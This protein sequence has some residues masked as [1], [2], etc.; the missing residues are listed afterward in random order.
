MGAV[1]SIAI[2][3]TQESSVSLVLSKLVEGDADGVATWM[4]ERTISLVRA[5]DLEIRDADLETVVT[6]IQAQA[7]RTQPFAVAETIAADPFDD[8]Q[9]QLSF[10]DEERIAS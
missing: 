6:L 4:G 9:P 1:A 10:P 8:I 5:Y 7:K 3:S 2:P